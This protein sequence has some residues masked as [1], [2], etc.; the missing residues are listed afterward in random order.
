MTKTTEMDEDFTKMKDRKRE[1]STE[2]WKMP[3]IP[4]MTKT[5]KERQEKY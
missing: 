2:I 5:I 4:I 3:S 1:Q